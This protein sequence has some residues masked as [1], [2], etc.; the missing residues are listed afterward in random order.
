MMPNQTPE[1]NDAKLYMLSAWLL[2]AGNAV[3]IVLLASGIALSLWYR[4][5]MAHHSHSLLTAWRSLL[6]GD[7]AGFLEAGLQIVILTPVLASAA[8][9]IYAVVHK[10]R[11]LLIPSLLVMGGL[12]LSLWIGIAW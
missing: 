8:I 7:P 2:R 3:S 1:Q 11:S 12:V 5:H 10:Q 6:R 4:N 9:C